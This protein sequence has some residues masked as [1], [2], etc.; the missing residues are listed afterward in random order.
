MFYLKNN[1]L[2]KYAFACGYVQRK[3]N[4]KTWVKMYQEHTTYHVLKGNL[5]DCYD[6]WQVFDSNE[7]TK[8]R[9][10]YK[11]LK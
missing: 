7:L 4:K 6:V 9:K 1:D 11:S 8:A 3:E 10:L 2:T 5:N